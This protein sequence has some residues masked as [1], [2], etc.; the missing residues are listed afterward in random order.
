MWLTSSTTADYMTTEKEG[1]EASKV[2][3]ATASNSIAT[4]ATAGESIVA[5]AASDS[6]RA[7]SAAS[8]YPKNDRLQE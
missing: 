7:A 6:I 2:I 8:N 3:V 5:S 1:S 4:S